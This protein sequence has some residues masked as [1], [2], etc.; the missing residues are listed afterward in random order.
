MLNHHPTPEQEYWFD[1][2]TDEKTV[3]KDLTGFL[4]QAGVKFS[5]GGMM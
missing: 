1:T 4:R 2:V 5:P 3:A